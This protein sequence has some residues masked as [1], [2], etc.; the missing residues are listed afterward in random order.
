M[1]FLFTN[2]ETAVVEVMVLPVLDLIVWVEI[3]ASFAPSASYKNFKFT[4]NIQIGYE[5]ISSGKVW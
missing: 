5:F 2:A 4:T 1:S 3:S